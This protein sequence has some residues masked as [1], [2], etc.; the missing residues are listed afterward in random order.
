MP[1]SHIIRYQKRIAGHFRTIALNVPQITFNTTRSKVPLSSLLLPPN[2]KF[3]SFCSTTSRFW[4]TGYF[5]RSTTN[6]LKMTL[7]TKRSKVPHIYIVT[8]SK[9]QISLLFDLLPAVFELQAI[10]RQVQQMTRNDQNTKG[11]K[12]LHMRIMPGLSPT[13]K[14]H[15]F[16]Q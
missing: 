14:I 11:P 6:N 4:V 5:E 7:N 16:L 2:P 3:H 10:L 15:S 9:S 12:V 1:F 8:T 13:T